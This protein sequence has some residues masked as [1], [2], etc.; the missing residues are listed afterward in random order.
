M[1]LFGMTTLSTSSI[2]LPVLARTSPY[3]VLV[4]RIIQ[5]GYISQRPLLILKDYA[6]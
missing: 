4:T 3:L 5:D 6:K 1:F 2:L